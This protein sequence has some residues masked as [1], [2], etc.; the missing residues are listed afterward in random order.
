MKKNDVKI[1]RIYYATVTNKK[2]QIQIDG[3]KPEGGWTATNLFTGKKIAIKTPDR[4]EGLVPKGKQRNGQAT[5]KTDGNVSVVEVPKATSSGSPK[6][7]YW[8]LSV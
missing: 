2:V 6:S 1:G 3:E 4:L 5:V 8:A 7:I